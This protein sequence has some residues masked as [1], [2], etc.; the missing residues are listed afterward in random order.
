MLQESE[1]DYFVVRDLLASSENHRFEL[2]RVTTP[3]LARDVIKH[4]D[5][6][7]CLVD[8][9]PCVQSRPVFLRDELVNACAIPVVLLAGQESFNADLEAIHFGV[10]DLI[11]KERMTASS[12]ERSIQ[13][14]VDRRRAQRARTTGQ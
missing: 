2:K 9:P 4:D 13:V 12:L 1:A 3:A 10:A 7:A 6:D 11:V 5:F 8:I 14:V